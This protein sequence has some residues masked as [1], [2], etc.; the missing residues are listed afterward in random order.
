LKNRKNPPRLLRDLGEFG[1]IDL[2]GGRYGGPVGPGETG[3]G[4]DAALLPVPRGKIALS[5]DLLVEG[6]HFDLSYFLPE[7]LGRRALSANL[8]DLAAMGA[9][10][11]CYLVGLAAPPDTPVPFLDGVFRGMARAA[12]E[13]G[14]RLL[15]GDTCRG[16]RIV[17]SI[18]IVGRTD[19]GKAVLRRGARPGDLIYVTGEPGWASLGLA[20]LSRGGR[21]GKPSAWQREAMRRHLVPEA[22]W[23]EGIAAASCGAVSAMIDASDGLLP[24]LGHIL[25]A[26]GGL[27]AVLDEEA[28][29]LSPL[30]R[31][32]AASL[33][34]SPAAAVLAGGED[35]ELVMTVRPSRASS[36]L[37]VSKAFPAGAARVGVVTARPGVFVRKADGTLKAASDFPPGFDHF[38]AEPGGKE[39]LNL[40]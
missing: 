28:L 25:R 1:F 39:P 37:R 2:V 24:D 17:I 6:T 12:R 7:E 27:G 22:R 9:R 21:P 3:I 5:T 32:A 11:L 20:L 38:G 18:S 33:G 4:D 23:R 40:P 29:P 10:P 31:R 30:F 15:G 35:Y 26:S 19:P 36:F 13:P 14:L 16:D 8:S 34:L